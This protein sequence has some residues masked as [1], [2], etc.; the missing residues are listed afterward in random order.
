MTTA[1]RV[2]V[3]AVLGRVLPTDRR[4][5]RLDTR[6]RHAIDRIVDVLESGQIDGSDR[7]ALEDARAV[8]ERYAEEDGR[9]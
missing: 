1:P 4:P 9:R 6:A 8:L 5:R 3:R 7:V 2:E